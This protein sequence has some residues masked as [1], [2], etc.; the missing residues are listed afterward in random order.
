MYDVSAVHIGQCSVYSHLQWLVT[1][2]L[3]AERTLCDVV[4]QGDFTLDPNNFPK[5]RMDQ[6]VN[7]L[8]DNGMH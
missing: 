6:F 4:L 5:D 2:W 1:K 7:K 8:H 3:I